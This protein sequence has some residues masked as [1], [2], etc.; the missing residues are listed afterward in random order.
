MKRC[1]IKNLIAAA[2]LAVVLAGWNLS[3]TLAA[4]GWATIKEICKMTAGSQSTMENCTIRCS[5]FGSQTAEAKMR[6]RF[7][8]DPNGI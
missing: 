1:V 3:A 7:L 2:L 4:P 6:A 8:R 5:G